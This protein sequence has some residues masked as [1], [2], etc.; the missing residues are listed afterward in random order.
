M[1]AD[2]LKLAVSHAGRRPYPDLPGRLHD[3]FR[4]LGAARAPEEAKEAEDAIWSAWMSHPGGRAAEELERATRAIVASDFPLAERIL[5]GLTA[6]RPDCAEAWH[7]RA[8]LYYM[9]GRDLESARSIHRTLELEPRHFGAIAALG[10]ILLSRDDREGALFA[11]DAALR[12]H[13]H[14]QSVRGAITKLL[15]RHD[16]AAH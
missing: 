15:A 13:P 3:L 16:A 6:G 7:K 14:L 10:E 11:F 2:T 9:Q 12:I 1:I 4:H 8:T 5:K